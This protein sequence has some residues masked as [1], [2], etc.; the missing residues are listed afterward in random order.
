MKCV[1][2][3][4][5]KCA[6]T[7]TFHLSHGGGGYFKGIELRT[8]G[9]STKIM[10]TFVHTPRRQPSPPTATTT[11]NPLATNDNAVDVEVTSDQVLQ[12][13]KDQR[14]KDAKRLSSRVSFTIVQE[15]SSPRTRIRRE[16]RGLDP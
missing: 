11:R 4:T 16:Y 10:R 1:C 14:P 3:C 15:K 2:A 5:T 12:R 6:C 7:R 8:Y 13:T 9:L